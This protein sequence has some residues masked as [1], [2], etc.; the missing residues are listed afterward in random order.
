M[1]GRDR[2]GRG[3]L[4]ADVQLKAIATV[5]VG[6]AS[7]CSSMHRRLASAVRQLRGVMPST[8]ITR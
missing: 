5:S 2:H 7:T 1:G 8:N 4:V 6:L 3:A